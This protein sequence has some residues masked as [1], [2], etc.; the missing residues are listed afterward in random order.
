MAGLVAARHARG[1]FQE[2]ADES[3]GGQEVRVAGGARDAAVKRHVFLHAVAAVGA[4][5][6]DCGPRAVDIRHVALLTYCRGLGRDFSLQ[7]ATQI[8]DVQDGV[9]RAQLGGVDAQRPVAR[10]SGDEDAAALPRFHDAVLPQARHR[11]ADDGAADAELFGQHGFG[12]QL[13]TGQHAP[14]VDFGE[15]ALGD[16]AAGPARAAIRQS[17]KHWAAGVGGESARVRMDTRAAGSSCASGTMRKGR[18]I[19]WWSNKARTKMP[20]ASLSAMIASAMAMD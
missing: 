10:Q 6:R 7:R 3:Q 2:L 1:G 14:L 15:Q 20:S 19:S 16:G 5:L 12:G 13:F 8:H 4:R 11:F 17:T 18:G 9:Q